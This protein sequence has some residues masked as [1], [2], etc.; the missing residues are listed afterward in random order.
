MGVFSLRQQVVYTLLLF[1]L[2][3]VLIPRA[4]YSSDVA[5]WQRWGV[6][7]YEHGLGNVYQLPDNNYNPLYHYVLWLYGALLGSVEKFKY[8]IHYLKAF[9]LVFDFAGAFWAASLVGERSRRFG[10][11]LLL[12]LNI[13]YLYNTLVWE[14]VDSIYTFF[15]FGAVVLALQQRSVGSV[16]FFVLA[17]AAKTQAI[18]FLPPLLLL[19]VPQWWRRPARLALALAAG[20]G[21][22]TLVLAPFIWWSWES[23]LPRIIELNRHAADVFPR[24][25]MRAFNAWYL[26]TPPGLHLGSSDLLVVGG[27]PLRTWG[28][29]LFYGFSALAL[30]P[31]LVA[32]GRALRARPAAGPVPDRALV[33]LSC[34]IIP[35]LFCFFNTQMHERYWHAS[36]LFLAAYGFLRRD[37]LPY[38]LVSVAYLLN[39]EAVQ[40]HLQL[41]RYSVAL[42][43]PLFIAGLFALAIVLILFNIYRLAPWRGTPAQPRPLAAA[44]AAPTQG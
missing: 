17:L 36:L 41:L 42:F 35:L 27:L 34:G 38:A 19:W 1:V 21:L 39:L 11:A 8:Y 16:L 18:I 7:I 23:Y 26:Y 28:M 6:Y 9:T 44:S 43:D 14:Q 29:L 40:Q 13:A 22:A 24:L 2:L 33:L 4:G 32:S 5:Y 20:A 30:A 31:L 3:L 12:L 10:L 25:T 15:A 37:Y